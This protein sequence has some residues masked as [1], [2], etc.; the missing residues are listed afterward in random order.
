[1]CRPKCIA[2]A[3]AGPLIGA[4]VCL[5][6]AGDLL[7]QETVD[8][9]D[10]RALLE[11]VRQQREEIESL[12]GEVGELRAQ[13]GD[14]WLTEQRAKEIRTL[15][16]DVLADADRRSSL[17]QNGMTAGWDDN[18]FLASPDGRFLLQI[19]GQMQFRWI[20]NYQ[21][22]VR[23]VDSFRSGF[24]NTRSKLTFRGHIF[25]P[26]LTY[27][28]RYDITRNEPGLVNGIA[29]LQD[30]WM[31]YHL[32][33]DFSVR[34]GQFKL[35][36]N[37]EELVSSARQL[38]VERSLVNESVN[39]G[40]S[41]GIELAWARQNQRSSI[42]ISDGGLD[43]LGGFGLV[44]PG[45]EPLNEAALVRDVEIALTGR[46]EWKLAGT[47]EQFDDFTSP[48]GDSFGLL[49]GVAGHFQT[50]E[51]GTIGEDEE[52]WYAATFDVS[53]E[54]GGANAFFAF[55]YH[56]LDSPDLVARDLDEGEVDVYGIVGQGGLYF[57][58]KLEVFAGYEWG[59]LQT[60]AT[61]S[62][63]TRRDGTARRRAGI[64]FDTLNVATVGVT[65]YIDG[66]DA[67]WTTDFGVGFTEVDTAFDSDIAGFRTDQD[68]MQFQ[69]VFRTQFQLLF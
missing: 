63:G 6:A 51:R 56:H 47:W 68:D 43:N 66:H 16:A 55:I 9:V 53:A 1:M 42:A 59:Q 30:A 11:E 38:T 27:L 60:T 48:V 23:G 5:T 29:F 57:T 65:Y 26:D 64:A 17:L 44:D 7:A 21:E 22:D 34:F 8:D 32:N 4:A 49:V 67:K 13:T 20:Q 41:Q 10:V 36:F 61:T 45:G 40:R 19:D 46:H 2:A 18:F 33:N 25:S 14:N 52:D 54:W 69:I 37:R 12:R 58:P 62:R 24:E 50:G 3:A 39:I 31:R 28:L 15:V 35:P